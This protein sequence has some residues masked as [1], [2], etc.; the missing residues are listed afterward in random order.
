MR[1]WFRIGPVGM[2]TKVEKGKPKQQ[3][4]GATLLAFVFLV[5][6]TVAASQGWGPW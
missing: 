2:S 3:P 4:L 6:C 5:G 1:V